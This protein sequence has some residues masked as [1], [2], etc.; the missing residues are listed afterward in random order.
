MGYRRE[1]I[2]L[3]TCTYHL[4]DN[5]TGNNTKIAVIAKITN[6]APILY[7]QF[8]ANKTMK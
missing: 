8:V 5:N 2:H 3:N 4:H 1:S 6:N 7:F